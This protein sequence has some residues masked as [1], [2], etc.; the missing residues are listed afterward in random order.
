[1]INL[2]TVQDCREFMK[3]H[4][5]TGFEA[6]LTLMSGAMDIDYIS[7]DLKPNHGFE[8]FD[9]TFLNN[10]EVAELLGINIS[11]S[12]ATRFMFECA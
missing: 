7:L 4:P 10:A 5:R 6:C 9:Q 2:N 3:N 8:P 11:E 12:I 1:M